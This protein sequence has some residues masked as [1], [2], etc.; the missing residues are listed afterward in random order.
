MA[1][2]LKRFRKDFDL[3]QSDIADILGIAQSFISKVE[4]GVESFP[5]AHYKTLCVKFGEDA[6]KKYK[7]EDKIIDNSIRVAG[8]GNVSN[9][10]AI[11]GNISVS[12]KK[13]GGEESY[14][15]TDGSDEFV[16]PAGLP[17]ELYQKIMQMLARIK[18]L[19][20][21]NDQLKKDKAILQEFVT[22]LQHNG[23]K[24]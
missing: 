2:D 19:E 3:K 7:S 13:E 5:Q 9:T 16:I 21:E 15:L 24:K 23:K 20:E 10:G 11:D 1:F 12:V 4:R 22:F 17:K 8:D 18:R 14:I 6:V